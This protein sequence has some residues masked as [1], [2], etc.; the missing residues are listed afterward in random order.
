MMNSNLIDKHL[1]LRAGMIVAGAT[2]LASAETPQSAADLQALALKQAGPRVQGSHTTHPDAQWFP[3]AG[4]GLFIHWGLASVG[5]KGDISWGMLANKPWTDVTITPNE[6]YGQVNRWNPDRMDYSAILGAAKAAGFTYAVM[7]TKH[8][9]GFTLWPSAF[10]DIGTKQSFGGRDFVREFTDACRKHG[11][12]AGLY[13]SPPDWWFDRK[14][15]S[16]SMTEP[17]LDMDHKPVTLPTKPAD[18]KAKRAAMVRGHIRELLT[19]YGKIDLF[20]F[21]GG[22]GEI[23][24]TEIRQLQPGM[25]VNRRNGSSGDF[26]DTERKMPTSRPTGW[27]EMCDTAWPAGKWSYT[28]DHGWDSAPQVL[29][30]L[31]S[32]RAWGGN[33]LANVGPKADGS[34]PEQALSA[35]REMA[36][37]M[38]HSR[39]SVFGTEGGAW[40]EQINVPTTIRK[41]IAYLHLLPGFREE[42]VWRDAPRPAKALLLRTNEPVSI[43]YE[44]R[45]LRLTIPAGAR[46]KIDDVVKIIM[47][48]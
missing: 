39:E 46:T 13:Y 33:L 21:D 35:W 34:I 17:A 44:D 27:F 42:V 30:K 26:D 28:E 31:V 9:D 43:Q 29:A 45:T 14:Y 2:L 48:N 23:S 5:A 24:Y 37:W 12:K 8:H 36:A 41:G 7:V 25:V 15:K 38:E 4:L 11:L 40:P 47:I 16:F 32:L 1:L 22:Q 18:H 19:N 6:Y 20:W 3:G 10:G